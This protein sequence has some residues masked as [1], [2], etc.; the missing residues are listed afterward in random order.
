MNEEPLPARRDVDTGGLERA[1]QLVE[2]RGAAA[3]LR[4]VVDGDV[5]LDRSTGCA[6]DSLFWPFSAS[7][8]FVAMLVHQLAQRGALSLDDT[9][10]AHWPEF[11]RAG[12]ES[13]TIRQ[14]LQHRSGM[15]VVGSTLGEALA[16]P[17]WDRSVRRIERAR[18][19]WPAGEAS[20]YQYISYGFILGELV[21]R[22]TGAKVRDVMDA[23]LLHPLGLRDTFLG[24]PDDAWGRRV[25]LHVGG[26]SGRVAQAAINRRAVRRA[27]IPSAGVSTTA[28]DLARF[29]LMLL[30]GGE[31]DG[32]RVL[33]R[34]V[35]EQART[36]SS[37]GEVDR[38]VK[39]P[40]RWSQ[41]FQLGGPRPGA[42]P[43]PMGQTS[44]PLTFGHNGSGCCIGWA[45]PTRGLAVAYLS[46][47]L[48]S[49]QV[50]SPHQ[51]AVADAILAAVPSGAR[52]T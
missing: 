37:D 10:A 28:R 51:A 39:Q 17:S 35:V 1:W 3:Q 21:Q 50:D 25:P 8:P 49:A 34:A 48:T 36:P 43:H 2:A 4:V 13:I 24:L 12:K 52:L 7:K 32:V 18:P 41:G 15:A 45:D 47:R 46:N 20:A 11:G 30:R 31:L 38:F 29:Y 9:V 22:V 19:A 5:V 26:A 23:E 16:V 27:V 6:P 33:D 40:I 42:V 14:V 44:S